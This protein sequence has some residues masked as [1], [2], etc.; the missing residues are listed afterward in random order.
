MKLSMRARLI[1]LSLSIVLCSLAALA[2]VTL[3]LSRSNALQQLDTRIGQMTSVHAREISNWVSD[4]QR[5]SAAIDAIAFVPD[6]VPFLA[7][8]MEAGGFD[9][10]Y[11]VYGPERAIAPNPF[12]DG[13]DATQRPWYQ[14]AIKAGAAVLTTP[15]LDM[16]TGRLTITFAKPLGPAQQPTAVYGADMYLDTVM[17][18][19]KGIHPT[20]K[21]FAFL[22]GEQGEIL[23]HADAQR[24]GEPVASLSAALSLQGLKQLA[25]TGARAEVQEGNAEQFVYAAGVQGTP[26][27]LAISVDAE[28]ATAHVR[29]LLW[30]SIAVT[31][32]CGLLAMVLVTL[33]VGQQMRRLAQVRDALQVIA[34]SE[35]DLT[36]RLSNQGDDEL[37]HIAQAFNR[38]VDK[39][40]VVL[41]RI[42]ES[43]EL[44]RYASQ[45]IASG[46]QDLSSRTERQA[47]ALQQTAAAMEQ[48]TA[49]VQL[50]A[51]SAQQA[52]R[53]AI[54]ASE[55]AEQGGDAMRQMVQTM[56]GIDASSQKIH[57]IIGV[58]D[59]IAFQT[60]ILALNAAVEAARAGEQGRGFA[61]VASEVRTLAQRSA[62]AAKEIKVLIQ[63]SA[64]QVASGN[65]QIQSAGNTMGEVLASV[66]QVTGVVEAMS[67]GSQTQSR[68]ITEI[69]NAVQA[70]DQSTQ[71]NA[72]LVEEASAASHSLQHQAHELADAV[73]GF[74]LPPLPAAAR[75]LEH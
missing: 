37:A 66:R 52:D 75:L 69:G 33:V 73:A 36:V 16:N 55:V 67:A 32:V 39:V 29:D 17:D 11:I 51:Q 71:Q 62:S 64:S 28:S 46:N 26:W 8:I 25:A 60:N 7:T 13:Y 48:L 50:N 44:V 6:P 58:I 18:L 31:V 4:K 68:D 5:I 21:S 61:V 40:A 49:A 43:A 56:Q 57:D 23:A 19:V 15:Y 1:G 3:Y 54:R 41:L 70:M 14:Q 24:I 9:D 53:L 2:S 74:K 65:A 47:S 72:A 42:R 10:A 22:L 38:F 30:L 35:G 12:P 63:E 20:A 45:E 34:S 27:T 59:G